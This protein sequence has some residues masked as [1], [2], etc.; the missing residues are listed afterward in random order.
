MLQVKHLTSACGTYNAQLLQH[1]ELYM[2]LGLAMHQLTAS[3]PASFS[4]AQD[5]R[6][7]ACQ[8]NCSPLLSLYIKTSLHK[9]PL[10]AAYT[11]PQ[12]ALQVQPSVLGPPLPISVSLEQQPQLPPQQQQLQWYTVTPTAQLLTELLPL[13]VSFCRNKLQQQQEDLKQLMQVLEQRLQ[14]AA[15]SK[16]LSDGGQL[17]GVQGSCVRAPAN[18]LGTVE[19]LASSGC[20]QSLWPL[21]QNIWM[22]LCCAV[23]PSPDLTAA[24]VQAAATAANAQKYTPGH[25][26]YSCVL[27]AP[28]AIAQNARDILHLM[29][30]LLRDAATRCDIM[31]QLHVADAV[32]AAMGGAGAAQQ[33]T[34]PAVLSADSMFNSLAEIIGNAIGHEVTR[35]SPHSPSALALAALSAG[36]GSKVQRQ[37][38]S[39]LGTMVKLDHAA[40]RANTAKKGSEGD[41]Q[42]SAVPVG[43]EVKWVE[44]TEESVTARLQLG[45]AA[46]FTAAALLA[47]ATGMQQVGA[48]GGPQPGGD[49]HSHAAA[50]AMLPSLYILGRYC[51][52]RAQQME[53]AVISAKT[54]HVEVQR[55]PFHQE[56]VIP[57]VQQWLETSINQQQLVAAGYT[58]QLLPQQLQQMVAALQALRDSAHNRQPDSSSSCTVNTCGL[59]A[60]RQLQAAG[61]ILCS[62]AVPSLCNNPTCRNLSGLTEL[63]V[64]SG[65]SCICAGC[66]VARYCGR[67]CQRI[68]WKQHKPVCAALAA[69]AAIAKAA[70]GSAVPQPLTGA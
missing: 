53:P 52:Q 33:V 27:H 30:A 44:V 28:D 25:F 59:E 35:D 10:S 45:R 70:A 5:V 51:M 40:V 15:A 63:S 65:R 11:G 61:S 68:A 16:G 64:V 17:P 43:Q 48:M 23:I 38:F 58:P 29:E 14:H 67:A 9:L 69:A 57:F 36:P 66:G 19:K 54:K 3:I 62:F 22:L 60:V 24:E 1:L 46:A 26:N 4:K 20:P 12:L 47:G 6:A 34:A 32:A 13:L 41:Q 8:L 56:L 37:L 50:T 39:L 42:Q 2:L 55:E 18:V 21:A 49:G 31:I 7:G